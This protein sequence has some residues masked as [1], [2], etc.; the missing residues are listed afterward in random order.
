MFGVGKINDP[1]LVRRYIEQGMCDIVNLS[2]QSIADPDFPKKMLAGRDDEIRKCIYCNWCLWTASQGNWT[3]ECAINYEQGRSREAQITKAEKPKRVLVVGGGVGGMEAARVSNLRGHDVTLWEKGPQLGGLAAMV[4]SMPKIFVRSLKNPV[5]WLSR[6]LKK[7]KVKV[8]LNR[9]VTVEA[10]E[11]AKP[12]VVL[13]ATG[14]RPASPDIPG[15]NSDNVFT[16]DDYLAGKAKLGQKVAVLGG[17]YASEIA[18]SIA[19]GGKEVAL[20]S[21]GGF[22]SLTAAPYLFDGL[23]NLMLF[24]FLAEVKAIT[25]VKYKEITKEGV[26]YVDAE[27]KE[28][29]VSADTV[30]LATGR[31]PNRELYDALVGKVPELYDIGDC[32]RP[33]KIGTAIHDAARIARHI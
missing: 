7:Q 5:Q 26:K 13:V 32:W 20:I 16:M 33:D 28:Q 30:I 29:L 11:E 4:S 31:V 2:R 23:R 8:E 15:V 19:R 3:V 14:S 21:E 9:E 27:G 25:D 6:H 12:D 22:D 18:V 24:G 17:G 1:R 10:V